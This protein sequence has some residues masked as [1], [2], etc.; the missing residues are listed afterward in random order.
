MDPKLIKERVQ[1]KRILETFREI[2]DKKLIASFDEHLNKW[3]I[4]CDDFGF[5]MQPEY[6]EVMQL[7]RRKYPNL[8][9]FSCM[10]H[11]VTAGMLLSKSYAKKESLVI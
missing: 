1:I 3:C 11:K 7:L 10:L 8:Q 4:Y 2:L 5:Y 9:F 6:Q